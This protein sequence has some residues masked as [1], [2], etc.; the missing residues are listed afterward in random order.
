MT[1]EIVEVQVLTPPSTWTTRLTIATTTDADQGYF[2]EM[3]EFNL[4]SP[5]VRFIDGS[6]TDATASFLRLDHVRIVKIESLTADFTFDPTSPLAGD[7]VTF[8]ARRSPI[9][10]SPR[11]SPEGRT[12]PPPGRGDPTSARSAPGTRRSPRACGIPRSS[13]CRSCRSRGPSSTYRGTPG[14]AA[15]AYGAPSRSPS[16]FFVRGNG[17]LGRTV[18]HEEPNS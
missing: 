7:T 1:D 4:G 2:L 12:R 17:S 15:N 16:L 5:S 8:T 9:E 10:G 3:A 6:S 18:W 14:P 13:R 11:P